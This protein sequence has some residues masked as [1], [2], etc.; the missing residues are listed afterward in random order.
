MCDEIRTGVHCKACGYEIVLHKMGGT[1]YYSVELPV[2]FSWVSQLPYCLG[3]G[4]VYDPS[5][6]VEQMPL[7][8]E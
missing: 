3:C 1:I 7:V 2:E 6:V 4:V 8:K 5:W